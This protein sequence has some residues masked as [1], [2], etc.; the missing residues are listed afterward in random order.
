MDAFFALQFVLEHLQAPD[1]S[2]DESGWEDSDSDSGGSS[3]ESDTDSEG[4]FGRQ[5]VAERAAWAELCSLEMETG[6]PGIAAW[7]HVCG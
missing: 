2:D 3:A 7:Y 5:M 6:N 1:S 4:H